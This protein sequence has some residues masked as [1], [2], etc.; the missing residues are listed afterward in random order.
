[1]FPSRVYK[2]ANSQTIVCLLYFLD[3]LTLFYVSECLPLYACLR[4]GIKTVVRHRVDA[5]VLGTERES[6]KWF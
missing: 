1:M 2:S 5:W 6:S 4:P 3:Y